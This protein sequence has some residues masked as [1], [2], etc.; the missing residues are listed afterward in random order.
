MIQTKMRRMRVDIHRI[1]LATIAPLEMGDMVIV[2]RG[3]LGVDFNPK[4]SP[5]KHT[6]VNDKG[7]DALADWLLKRRESSQIDL[8]R[9]AVLGETV[10]FHWTEKS[11]GHWQAEFSINS[12]EA[13]RVE[14]DVIFDITHNFTDV[15][16]VAYSENKQEMSSELTG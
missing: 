5:D 12:P 11:H 2:D 3:D 13:G 16:F 1:V 10:P 9:I 6:F 4:G 15:S 14:Y 8:Y 7:A